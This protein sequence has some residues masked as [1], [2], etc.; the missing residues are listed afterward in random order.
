MFLFVTIDNAVITLVLVVS[1]VVS[2]VC[3]HKL[4]AQIA[5]VASEGRS[6]LCYL[7]LTSFL[8]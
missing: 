4:Y 8:N 3:E 2:L 7:N 6:A 1:L 5:N